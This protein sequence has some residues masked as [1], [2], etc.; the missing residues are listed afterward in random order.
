MMTKEP[1]F[2]FLQ[3]WKTAGEVEAFCRSIYRVFDRLPSAV[4][5]AIN[6]GDAY[7][8]PREAKRLVEK[9]G[10]KMAAAIVME[11]HKGEQQ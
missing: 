8:D 11:M 9:H 4:R 1:C 3:E 7:V 6:S 10:A 2:L 5:I